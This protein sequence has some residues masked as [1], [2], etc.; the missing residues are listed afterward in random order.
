MLNSNDTSVAIKGMDFLDTHIQNLLIERKMPDGTEVDFN[1]PIID[2]IKNFT[3][4]LV[5]ITSSGEFTSDLIITEDLIDAFLIEMIKAKYLSDYVMVNPEGLQAMGLSA[6]IMAFF[7]SK[8]FERTRKKI[9]ALN[10][11]KIVHNEEEVP[12]ELHLKKGLI[13]TTT[14]D[15]QYLLNG[16]VFS[17]Q[18]GANVIFQRLSFLEYHVE[19]YNILGMVSGLYH[20]LYL[21]LKVG[22]LSMMR[23]LRSQQ[24]VQLSVEDFE[25]LK[26]LFEHDLFCD[27]QPQL[28]IDMIMRD[29]F[30]SNNF[31]SFRDSQMTLHLVDI[32]LD[33]ITKFKEQHHNEKGD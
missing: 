31:G 14:S 27:I 15:I 24:A 19:K 11:V 22:E 7:N 23:M 6:R 9:Q 4:K 32:H 1:A 20:L 16:D 28:L 26:M 3:D 10:F 8:K 21:K 13:A 29:W 2:I 33:F 30:E 18:E 5:V 17:N 12:L 25:N